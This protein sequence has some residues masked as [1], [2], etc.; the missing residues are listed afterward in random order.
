M[1]PP[2]SP[3]LI[4]SYTVPKE[5]LQEFA[6]LAEE[7]DVD[8]FAETA[9]TRQVAARQSDYH[10]RRFD[11]VAV[12][13]ADAFQEGG[14]D[15]GGYKDAMRL[16][17]LEQEEVRVKRAIEEK[18]RLEREEGKLKM[19]LDKTPPAAEL[20]D[21]EMELA[22]AKE[23]ATS[24]TKR[25]RRWDVPEPSDENADPNKADT[26]EW[27]KEALEASAPKKRRSRWD[28][29]P[30]EAETP[31]RSRWDQ[32]PAVQD[33]PMV[34]I[35]MNA[36]GI[37]QDDKHN[38]YLTDEELDAILPPTG[39]VVVTPPPGYAP[40]VQPRKLQAPS[41]TEV[42]GFH[43]QESSD[44]AAVA[45]AAGLAPE[46]PTEIPGVGTLAFFKAEDA[47]YFAKIMKEEDETELSVD[48][49]KERKIMRLLLKIKNGTP[50]V[51]RE[52]GA[53]PLFDKIL[54][55]LMERT[56][57]DQE[58]H[59][60]VKVIDRVL[61][62]LDDLVRPYVHKILVVI[63]PLLID[64]DYYARVEGREI[65]SNLSKAAGLAHMISTMRPDID[66]ADE[67]VRNTTARA[68]S[69]VASALGIPSLL[70]FLKAV[71]RSKKSWQARHTGIRIVQQ[72][73][74]MM[75]CAV[76]PH[77]RNLVDCIAHGL[78]D[79][80]QKVRTMTA[81]G[82]AA[83]AEAAAPYG[84]ESFDNVL[85]PLWLGIRLH[86]GKGLAA[87]LKAIGFIIPLMDPEYASY[88]T[89][90]VTVILIREFQTSDEEMKKIVLKVVK[91]CAA[92]EGVTPGYIK[93][94]I[95][96]DFF[97]SFW[98]RRM[99]LDRRNYRQVVETTVELAQKVGVSEIVGRI[100]NELKDEAEPYRKMVMETITKVVATLGASDIDERLEV[101]LVDGIIYSFQ[102]QT[103]EDQ[104][105]LDGFGTVVNALGIRVKPY[106]TQIVSTILW[107]LNNKSAKVRQQAAD[108]TT[109]LAVVIKQCGEDQLLSKLGLVLFE[110]LGEE[111]PDTL[112]SIIAAEGA[113]ANVVGMTQMNPPVKDLLP[114]MTPILRNRHEKVQEASINLIGRIADRGAEFVPAREWMRIC[115]ELLDLLK[116]HKKGIR[117]AAVNSFGYI[118]KSLGP[119]DVLSVLLTNLRVQDRQSRVCSTVAIAIVAETCGPFTCIPAILNEYRTAELNVRT[120]CLKALS[121]V[122]EYVGPQSAY[123]CD[124]VVTMLED[125]LTDRDLVH[126][127]TASTIVKHLA[128][129]VAGLGCEDSMLH[130][131][132]LVWPNCFETSPHVIGAVMDAIEAMRVTLGPGVLLSYVLQGLFHPARKVREVYWRVY[133]ALYLGAQDSLVPFY[134]D[135]GELSEGKNVYD[136]HPLQVFI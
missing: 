65:I 15:E 16:A 40:M 121:F 80:Q 47:Q 63:E 30:A 54:P 12:E 126:R 27:S 25:K 32:T 6:E 98:V 57:E 101:R 92:T 124:S 18:E 33:T 71:C 109:R 41:V 52:F 119:Q 38:R 136:K 110:Q 93:H 28:S 91:Q 83:L 95:L 21:V 77:L 84:I 120:G 7:E 1:S 135:L 112:G 19:D 56:L 42:G 5:I 14:T 122:F 58:R 104:V 50:P 108:L 86:R 36:P 20:Q 55:L 35:I 59:L 74:I 107:R 29:T 69:V 106:L 131:M 128:L 31:K 87:F 8:P 89:T 3:R 123:Y 99:A 85:K 94:D 102:E 13:S 125:A 62:K 117:R 100:V 73:A 26:G 134:P 70:P 22:A 48:E 82:L 67:Y 103:T 37:S 72:I 68:F 76:L 17:R 34:P 44:A 118:A 133:N 66:H 129:G 39:Y 90:E 64:E 105:M 113:I 46:L 114:R 53:G 81:L 130:L 79:E 43:I 78:S 111:Y 45:A 24:G 2:G 115:F 51:R 96:P 127:Q 97:K 10:N 49:M 75:G 23:L 60:L 88:Y 132:N 116:A 9:K 4:D 61:Y 11:R